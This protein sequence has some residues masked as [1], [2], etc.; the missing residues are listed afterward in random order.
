MDCLQPF[1]QPALH[2]GGIPKL[3]P[4]MQLDLHFEIYCKAGVLAFKSSALLD[5][6]LRDISEDG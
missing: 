1:V 3:Q 2:V 5:L 4:F 6:H